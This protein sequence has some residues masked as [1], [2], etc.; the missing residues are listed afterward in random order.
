MSWVWENGPKDQAQRLVL[1]AL[2]D[3]CDDQGHCWPSMERIGQKASMTARGARGVIR[4]L[5][6]DGWISVA[7]GGGRGGCSQY[8]IHTINPERQTRNEEPGMSNPEPKTRNTAPKTRNV[9]AETRNQRSAEPSITIKEPS[10]E[11]RARAALA[12]VLGEELGRAFVAHRKALKA[13][14]TEHG[15]R[16]MAKKLATMADPIGSTEQS[17]TEGW[18]GVF[19]LKS[20]DV[21]PFPS[22]GRANDGEQLDHHLDALKARLA[23]Q[24]LE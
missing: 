14:M 21:H 10:E 15:A 7:V 9:T 2:A 17:I 16:L 6:I 12:P 13:P 23:H 1:L 20:A 11:E 22:K 24:R 4:R 19:P 3:Y 18:K 8:Q 5:E